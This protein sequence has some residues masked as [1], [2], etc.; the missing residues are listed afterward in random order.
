MWNIDKMI[1]FSYSTLMKKMRKLRDGN[2]NLWHFKTEFSIIKRKCVQMNCWRWFFLSFFTIV[3][4]FIVY[5]CGMW[6]RKVMRKEM[7]K[8]TRKVMRKEMSMRMCMCVCVC[9]C[10]NNGEYFRIIFVQKMS[11]ISFFRLKVN[12]DEN[13]TTPRNKLLNK[14]NLMWIMWIEYIRERWFETIRSAKGNSFYLCSR[15]HKMCLNYDALV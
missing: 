12:G 4:V 9:K 3:S 6:M 10:E 13:A 11:S 8:E 7:R 14:L 2:G 5:G 1:Y 15:A